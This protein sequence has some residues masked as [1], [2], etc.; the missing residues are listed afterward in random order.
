MIVGEE[1]SP[2]ENSK[3]RLDL[4]ALDEFGKLVVIELKRDND[5]FHMDLQAIRYA[6]T[7]RL[8]SIDKIVEF[9][10][11]FHNCNN[12]QAEKAIDNFLGGDY[13]QK[14]DFD[15][16][17]I[18]LVNQYFSKDIT[19]TVLW[20]N[21]QGLDIKCIKINPYKLNSESIW[22]IDTIIPVKEAQEYQLKLKEKK[23]S[24]QET[25]R[26]NKDFSKYQFNG[27]IFGKGRLVLAVVSDY[28]KNNPNIDIVH[29]QDTF[30]KEL[31]SRLETAILY[32]DLENNSKFAER[33][34]KDDVITLNN[35][36]KIIVC[37]QWGVGNIDR[38]ID[39]A[40][41]LGYKIEKQ[42]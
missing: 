19:N 9:Y 14:L 5:G 32:S 31:Q 25:K 35:A 20:L 11:N 38:F 26:N 16:V 23:H 2:F 28:C 1:L 22:D 42:S 34:F 33:Y 37:N 4:L 10:G 17:R 8:F 3:K 30:P 29:L 18:I 15:N 7:V 13:A 6:S 24:D 21:E 12:E 40:T 36:S 41:K 27:G 39:C